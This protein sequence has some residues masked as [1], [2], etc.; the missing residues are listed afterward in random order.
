MSAVDEPGASSQH[1]E[2]G[3]REKGLKPELLAAHIARLSHATGTHCLRDRA[4]NPRSCGVE[5]PKLRRVLTS[6][7]LIESLGACFIRS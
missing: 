5:L 4:L 2:S 6:A 7:S 3:R 1:I